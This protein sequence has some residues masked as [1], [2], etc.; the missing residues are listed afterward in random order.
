VP[1]LSEHEKQWLFDAFILAIKRPDV[2]SE[3]RCYAEGWLANT[4]NDRALRRYRGK[5]HILLYQEI[6][7][8]VIVELL[9]RAHNDHVESLAEKSEEAFKQY[10]AKLSPRNILH[11]VA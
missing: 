9:R 1:K 10:R 8:E 2:F 11:A 6:L 7:P 3:E 5:I 4:D